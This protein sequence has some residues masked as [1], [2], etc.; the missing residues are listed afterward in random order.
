MT[1]IYSIYNKTSGD[2]YHLAYLQ[3][4]PSSEEL[5]ADAAR[6]AAQYASDGDQVEL[7][8]TGVCYTSC[9]DGAAE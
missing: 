6:L 9:R 5:S 2:T 3:G 4:T 7:V 8:W 1:T